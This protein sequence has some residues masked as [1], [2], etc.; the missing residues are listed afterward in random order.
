MAQGPS[1][2]TH[3][4][5]HTHTH[6]HTPSCMFLIHMDVSEPFSIFSVYTPA[7]PLVTEAHST[8]RR[9]VT[10]VGREPAAGSSSS[11]S[12]LECLTLDTWGQGGQRERDRERGREGEKERKF[13]FH[14][15]NF[16]NPT[17]THTHRALLQTASSLSPRQAV[18]PIGSPLTHRTGGGLGKWRG[19]STHTGSPTH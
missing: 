11:S 15:G 4:H 13:Y 2:H 7:N 3:T 9:P 12:S 16:Q 19:F 17:D 5:T 14:P 1:P 18:H 6:I 8:A 10:A